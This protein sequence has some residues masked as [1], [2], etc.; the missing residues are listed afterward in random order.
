MSDRISSGIIRKARFDQRLFS[1]FRRHGLLGAMRLVPKNMIALIRLF[2]RERRNV[3]RKER[4]F[5]RRYG[6]DTSDVME[7]SPAADRHAA[8]HAVRYQPTSVET[9]DA[10][11][12]LLQIPYPDYDFVDFG[13]GK[14]RACLLAGMRPFH[15]VIGIEFDPCTHAI[16]NRN[17]TL[18]QRHDVLKCKRLLFLRDDARNFLP[19]GRPHVF[20]LYNPFDAEILAPVLEQMTAALDGGDSFIIYVHPRQRRLIEVSSRWQLVHHIEPRLGPRVAIYRGA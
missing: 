4:K 15:N 19:P 1:A 8:K 13:S 9:I 7:I 6:I 20:F 5:D 18:M 17:L 12:D 14:G 3:L 2:D 10:A 11:L 16:A